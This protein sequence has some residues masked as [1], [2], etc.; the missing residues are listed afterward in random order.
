MIYVYDY[1]IDGE[2][3][4]RKNNDIY[5]LTSYTYIR[6]II[7]CICSY[8]PILYRLVFAHRIIAA[9]RLYM[10]E[11]IYK[12]LFT[13]KKNISN[14]LYFF[15]TFIY[16]WSIITKTRYLYDCIGAGI[17]FFF[18]LTLNVIHSSYIFNVSFCVFWKT[19]IIIFLYGSENLYYT[20]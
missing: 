9:G 19:K 14:I 18:F 8:L 6:Y 20:L 11:N 12:T 2:T 10:E 13:T 1:W 3:F 16:T 7:I 17:F 15:I 4:T 5:L